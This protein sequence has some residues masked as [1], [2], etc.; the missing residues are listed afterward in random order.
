MK[1]ITKESAE[2]LKVL[3]YYQVFR[4]PLRFEEI[5]KLLLIPISKEDLQEVIDQLQ[6]EKKIYF[7]KDHYCL[8]D[9]QGIVERRIQGEQLTATLIPKA[10]KIGKLISRFPFV[11]FVGISGSLSKG[12]ADAKTD[13]DFFIVT[14]K[15]RLWI[16][17]SILHLFKKL[18]YLVNMQKCFCMNYFIDDTDLEIEDK[19][20][21]VMYEI[22]T[23]IPVY[24]SSYYNKFKT[25]N[26]WV[27]QMLPQ[28]EYKKSNI[29]DRKS[30][31]KTIAETC[32]H[33]LPLNMLNRWLMK[34]TDYKWKR[35]WRKANYPMEDYDLAFRT[36]IN[37]SK[38]HPKNHQ[39]LLL[40][41]LSDF[42]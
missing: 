18:A 21:F 27:R 6:Y 10:K 8:V 28:F 25:S 42:L 22:A 32:L 13:F 5:H 39:K 41:K 26:H 40:T 20:I 31:I 15:N 24:N 17:R 38:N 3:S 16:T 29:S 34:L 1:N 14:A 23:L 9:D 4:H 2:V 11:R 19:N 35:K 7:H 12:F 30:I 36:R 33:I 37:I